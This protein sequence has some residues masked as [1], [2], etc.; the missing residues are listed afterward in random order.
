MVQC[1]RP[2]QH[3]AW[4][5]L[6]PAL[7]YS[8]TLYRLALLLTLPMYAC[9]THVSQHRRDAK[10]NV[11]PA[12]L[13]SPRA[14]SIPTSLLE[15]L[16]YAEPFTAGFLLRLYMFRPQWP[17]SSCYQHGAK[18]SGSASRLTWLRTTG[19]LLRLR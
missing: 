1:C 2:Q 8:K 13:S 15:S 17:Q 12:A 19:L 5:S 10:E 18:P 16:T 7:Q 9:L 11:K 3:Q 14:F 4:H 6:Q